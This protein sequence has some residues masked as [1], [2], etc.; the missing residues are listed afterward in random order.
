MMK[1]LGSNGDLT[2]FH[3][4]L[5][6]VNVGWMVTWG[7]LT[8][9][10]GDLSNKNGDLSHFTDNGIQWDITNTNIIKYVY[11]YIYIY[12]KDTTYSY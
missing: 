3:S 8:K 10:N 12:T 1:K 9:E 7:D 4:D 2:G 11:T 6:G 5:M